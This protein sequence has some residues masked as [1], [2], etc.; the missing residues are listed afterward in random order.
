VRYSQQL[1][2][3]E[4]RRLRERVLRRDGYRCRRCGATGR[5][6]VHHRYYLR[7]HMAWQYPMR[8][9][10]TLCRDC[11]EWVH[12]RNPGIL[13]AL[14]RILRAVVGIRRGV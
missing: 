1:R 7:G 8:A 6:E 10:V 4:W 9:L 3:P 5:L 2:Q 11:H 13:A 14:G 12:G